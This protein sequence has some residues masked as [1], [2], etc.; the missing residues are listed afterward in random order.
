MAGLAKAI[1]DEGLQDQEFIDG[2]TEGID[3]L[4]DSLDGTT[5]QQFAESTGVDQEL[6]LNAARA[7]ANADSASIL[8]STSRSIEPG[9]AIARSAANLA[10]AHGQPGQGVGRRE[11]P[12]VGCQQPGHHRRGLLPLPPPGPR[13]L[14]QTAPRPLPGMGRRPPIG[15]GLELE[16]DDGCGRR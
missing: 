9:A 16:R 8:F 12:K 6:L 2:Q 15:S 1:L 13:G 7:Y 14:S 5:V 11:P 3:A 10:S 4:K